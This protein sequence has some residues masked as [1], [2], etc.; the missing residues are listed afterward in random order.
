MDATGPQTG[1]SRKA[2]LAAIAGLSAAFLGLHGVN[3]VTVD[4]E[5]LRIGEQTVWTWLGSMLFAASALSALGFMA[6][7][8][9]GTRWP[10]AVMAVLMLALSV[11]EVATVHERVEEEG[12]S[13]LSLLVLQ[14]LVAIAA[15]AL[16]V[17]LLRALDREARVWVV[18][19]AVAL[20]I[21]Q[22]GSTLDSE[23]DLP[24]ALHEAWRVAEELLELLVPAFI[25]AATLPTV[26]ERVAPAFDHRTPEAGRKP[27]GTAAPAVRE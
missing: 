7:Q 12:G 23:V 1:V 13:S 11:D 19:A 17:R 5:I 21:A 4:V 25:L 15:V 10:W 22:A 24:Y 27:A 9:R 20:V 2:V 26:W 8:R 16:F 3:R 6:L 14:P 18:L